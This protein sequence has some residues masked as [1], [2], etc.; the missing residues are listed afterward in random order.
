MDLPM[1][2]ED[3]VSTESVAPLALPGETWC[4]ID[5]DGDTI[6][7]VSDSRVYVGGPNRAD[8]HEF[9][10]AE[11]HAHAFRVMALHVRTVAAAERERHKAF[12]VLVFAEQEHGGTSPEYEAARQRY[13]CAREGLRALGVEP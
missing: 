10:D 13:I 3:D 9:R 6:V 12:L 11:M 5:D 1:D 7:I 2:L 4:G 8:L